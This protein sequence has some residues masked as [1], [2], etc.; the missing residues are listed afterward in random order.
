MN[1]RALIIYFFKK[2]SILTSLSMNIIYM[3]SEVQNRGISDPTKRSY[4]LKNYSHALPPVLARNL[5]EM[6][7]VSFLLFH[8]PF[9]MLDF[10]YF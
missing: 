8:A 7:E 6:S 5:L 2:I 9:H 10:V 1:F 4:V 3:L